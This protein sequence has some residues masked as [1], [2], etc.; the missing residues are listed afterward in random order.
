MSSLPSLEEIEQARKRLRSTIVHTPLVP[1]HSCSGT[2][3]ILLKLE[4]HQAVNS[5]KLRGIFN[6]AAS[7]DPQAR[8]RG[9]STVSAGNTAQAVAWA[10]RYFGVPARS[11]MPDSAPHTKIEA[12]RRY[13]GTPVLVPIDRLFAYLKN[14]EWKRESYCFIHPWTNRDVMTGH[15]SLGLE[16]LED[17]PDVESVFVPVGGG[18]LICGV[19]AAIK[20]LKPEV[21]LVA[22]EAA[23]C[24]H[25]SR[26]LE[27]GK[28]LEVP[29][30]TFCDGVAVP[31]VTS[32]VFPLLQQIVD[33]VVCVSDEEVKATIGRLARGNKILVE[34]AGALSVAAAL[35]RTR[36]DQGRTV[37]LVT[38]G[39]ID[40]AELLECLQREPVD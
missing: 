14:E 26:S 9:F 19:G 29:C 21:R 22:V 15:A 32:Q 39:S 16:I 2:S 17:C 8:K 24:P 31:Y 10:G 6:A 7:L 12:V 28:P 30:R 13:G 40:D 35:S 23:G 3:H 33:E 37:C 36:A 27:A 18:G 20:H 1:L 34:G 4:I 25:V 5:F 11:L 38:G